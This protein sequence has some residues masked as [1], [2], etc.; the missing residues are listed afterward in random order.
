MNKEKLLHDL[1]ESLESMAD[2]KR[3]KLASTYYPSSSRIIGVTVPNVKLV[4]KEMLVD[5]KKLPPPER[6]AFIKKLMDTGIFECRH[7]A[8]EYFE[9]DKEAFEQLTEKDL[10]YLGQG[11]DNWVLV[12]C[13]GCLLAGNMWRE[14]MI[15]DNKILGWLKSEDYW[16]RR[17]AVASTIPLN[18]KVRGG[19]GDPEKTLMICEKVME[20]RNDMIVKALSWA[21]RALAT[22]KPV[23]VLEFIEIHKEKLHKKVL[24]EVRNKIEKGTKN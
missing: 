19:K 11:L 22:R 16:W 10:D 4:A 20:D 14:G 15:S 13:Y 12:D 3:K 17:I 1:I 23:P 9:K 2:E 21:L 18:Q 24:R 8:L 5:L 6:I 7:I